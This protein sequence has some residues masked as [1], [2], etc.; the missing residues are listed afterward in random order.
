VESIETIADI[1]LIGRAMN[2]DWPV[3]K[4]Q[5]E[6]IVE[7]LM[8]IIEHGDPDLQIAASRT[9]MMADAL[10]QKRQALQE[11][12]LAL[13]QK[14]KLELIELA[15]KLGIVGNDGGS[16]GVVDTEPSRIANE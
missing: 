4:E 11:K 10:N 1:R 15:H 12:K 14:R 5:K 9:L 8:T 16:I 7:K 6:S 13:E 2:E 3:Y